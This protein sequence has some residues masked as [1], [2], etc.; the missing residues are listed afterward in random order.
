MKKN[1]NI[2]IFRKDIIFYLIFDLLIC[3]RLPQEDK[4]LYLYRISYMYYIVLGFI[5][6]CVVALIVSAIFHESDCN[7][8]D[9][10]MPFIEKRL[11]K[12][13][14]LLENN[15]VKNKVSF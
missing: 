1:I 2:C 9:L 6:T 3:L 13:E 7:N 8:P 12:Q 5:V 15:S 10:F 4:Y 14:L 11:R